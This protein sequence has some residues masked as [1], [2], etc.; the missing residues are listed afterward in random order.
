MAAATARAL[1]PGQETMLA[2]AARLR[3]AGSERVGWKIDHD[4]AEAD[5]RL[6]VGSTVNLRRRGSPESRLVGAPART[7]AAEG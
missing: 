6:V 7:T 3:E 4:I 1:I 5:W 2:C